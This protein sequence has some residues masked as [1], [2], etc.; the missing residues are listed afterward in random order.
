MAEGPCAPSSGSSKLTPQCGQKLTRRL[1]GLNAPLERFMARCCKR[2]PQRGQRIKNSVARTAPPNATKPATNRGGGTRLGSWVVPQ[3]MPPAHRSHAP[4]AMNINRRERLWRCVRMVIMD[5]KFYVL[6][7]L[8]PRLRPRPRRR[9]G[10]RA[11]NLLL[12]L[13]PT[14]VRASRTQKK[15]TRIAF[16]WLAPPE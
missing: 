5:S 6:W 13:I 9:R 8:T 10:R 16:A 14:A 11:L 1:S 3:N 2:K 7:H 12:G 15:R 4:N